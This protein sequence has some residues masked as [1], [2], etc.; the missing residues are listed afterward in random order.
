M[1][2]FCIY[3]GPVTVLASLWVCIHLQKAT[4]GSAEGTVPFQSV[5]LQFPDRLM[6]LQEPLGS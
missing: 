1:N 5:E 4:V 2:K 6:A 3:A